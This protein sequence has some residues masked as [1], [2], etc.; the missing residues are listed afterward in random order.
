MSRI[1]NKTNRLEEILLLL[2]EHPEGLTRTDLAQR[3]G[4]D[5]STIT[6]NLPDLPAPVYEENGKLFI[7][8]NADLILLRLSLH[9]A[10]SLHLASRLLTANL[11]RQNSHAAS[12]L[13][14]ISRAMRPLSAHLSRH[15]ARSAEVIDSIAL[16]DSPI[17]M[18]V[19]E[20]ITEGWARGQKVRVWHRKSSGDAI[21]T[22]ILSPYYIEPGAWG[23]S[24]YVI[25]L[26]E[27]PSEIRT[28]K[29]ER[30]EQAEMLSE[31]YAIPVEFEPFELL[32]DAWG[33]WY[34]ENEPV[35]V[36]LRFSP[37]VAGRVVETHWHRSQEV[38]LEPNGSLIWRAQVA[39]IQ[40][41]LPW[42][43]GWG[44]DVEV[45]APES[46][47][48]ILVGEVRRLSSLYFS[49]H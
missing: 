19:L 17:Y 15:V 32:K 33:I 48:V 20:T 49:D 38:E 31:G 42:I 14:K 28:L 4:V 39:A 44:A 41:M 9:E 18:R 45:L 5:R 6:R 7:D 34:T 23:R 13:R 22:Y 46:L 21:N 36:V 1:A 16:Y 12:A 25:G 10:L 3:L 29:I 26:R 24:T 27:P 47:R 11:D 37:L 40:E 30:I 43:R 2:I 8:R 35:S